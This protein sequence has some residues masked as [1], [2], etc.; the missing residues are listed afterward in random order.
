[1]Y[2][3]K[4]LKHGLDGDQMASEEGGSGEEGKRSED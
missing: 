2:V 3:V 4:A 1:M